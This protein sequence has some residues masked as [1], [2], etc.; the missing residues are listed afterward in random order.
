M[1]M[2]TNMNQIPRLDARTM[3]MLTFNLKRLLIQIPIEINRTL[4]RIFFCI[5]W[6]STEISVA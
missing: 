1:I 5:Q 6:L 3:R 2:I 4:D